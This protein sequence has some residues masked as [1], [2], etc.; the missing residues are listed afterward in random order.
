MVKWLRYFQRMLEKAGKILFLFAGA[1]ARVV[2][3]FDR[4]LFRK[5]KKETVNLKFRLSMSKT[6]QLLKNFGFVPQ[7]CGYPH[8]RDQMWLYFRFNDPPRY[9]Q[10]H[11]RLRKG[12]KGYTLV[13]VHFEPD[14]TQPGHDPDAKHPHGMNYDIGAKYFKKLLM[15]IVD[16]AK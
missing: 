3:F 16:E 7:G 14:W 15:V 8:T 2:F 13:S 9:Y 12:K 11:A 1:T 10:L 5:R 6:K 4:P